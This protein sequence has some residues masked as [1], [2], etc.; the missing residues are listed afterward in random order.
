MFNFTPRLC[1][2]STRFSA[3]APFLEL[4]KE[5]VSLFLYFWET[6][7]SFQEWLALHNSAQAAAQTA[8]FWLWA[9]PYWDDE[10]KVTESGQHR[11]TCRSFSLRADLPRWKIPLNLPLNLPNVHPSVPR[12]GWKMIRF[13]R[14]KQP[15]NVSADY[16]VLFKFNTAFGWRQITS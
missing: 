12:R 13:R 11:Q 3:S 4:K 1:S 14:A 6:H 5:A 8:S 9:W 10:D 15:L 7:L 2:V 16:R